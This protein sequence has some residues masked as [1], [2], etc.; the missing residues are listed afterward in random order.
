M[1][2]HSTKQSFRARWEVAVQ[3]TPP[4]SL[5]RTF[6]AYVGQFYDRHEFDALARQV[7][8]LYCLDDPQQARCFRERLDHRLYD[9]YHFPVTWDVTNGDSDENSA[10]TPS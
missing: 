8:G 7:H 5:A 6:A 10:T 4:A 9:H 2:K 3:A 1:S